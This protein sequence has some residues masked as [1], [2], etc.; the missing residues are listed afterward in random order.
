MDKRIAAG[1]TVVLAGVAMAA[2]ALYVA[3][4]PITYPKAREAFEAAGLEVQAFRPVPRPPEGAVSGVFVY[5]AGANVN[6]FR[7]K[8]SEAL[9]AVRAS[10]AAE[11]PNTTARNGLFLLVANGASPQILKRIVAVFKGL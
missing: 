7:F 8:N 6:V 5:A 9:E 4:E 10:K 1:V 3:P 11:G 2:V